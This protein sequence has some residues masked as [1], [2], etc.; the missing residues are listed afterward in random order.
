M[1]CLKLQAKFFE[2]SKNAPKEQRGPSFG[3]VQFFNNPSCSIL[4]TCTYLPYFATTPCSTIT[5]PGSLRTAPTIRAAGN[6]LDACCCFFRENVSESV[7]PG[8]IYA[9]ACAAFFFLSLSYMQRSLR[10]KIRKNSQNSDVITEDFH[11]VMLILVCHLI[12]R[13]SIWTQRPS[14]FLVPLCYRRNLLHLTVCTLHSK[15]QKEINRRAS[16]PFQTFVPVKFVLS[17]SY[18]TDGAA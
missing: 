14:L 1:I 4:R 11:V 16:I 7:D 12:I 18:L 15:M 13:T 3:R 5:I 10:V 9:P 6:I 8:S 17:V 2:N